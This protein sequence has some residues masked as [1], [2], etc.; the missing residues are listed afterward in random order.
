MQQ[1]NQTDH[2]RPSKTSVA[3][4]SMKGRGGRGPHV[5]RGKTS[6]DRGAYLLNLNVYGINDDRDKFRR[7]GFVEISRL[8][9]NNTFGFGPGLAWRWKLGCDRL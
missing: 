8:F 5:V 7:T 3:A 9:H 4:A 2:T 6:F 1:K